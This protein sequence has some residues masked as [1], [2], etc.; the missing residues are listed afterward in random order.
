ME[1]CT[2]LTPPNGVNGLIDYSWSQHTNSQ[3][4]IIPWC[5]IVFF[6]G[7][8]PPRRI[9]SFCKVLKVLFLGGLLVTFEIFSKDLNNS[10]PTSFETYLSCPSFW[11][12]LTLLFDYIGPQCIHLVVAVG[13]PK[14]F[15]IVKL[16]LYCTGMMSS[17]AQLAS[18]FAIL[19][20]G[21]MTPMRQ[22]SLTYGLH[23]YEPAPSPCPHADKPMA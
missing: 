16:S 14:W 4:V 3:V 6:F 22:L 12:I 8:Q 5:G 13:I 20:Q 9:F 17:P 18:H 1:K 19:K 7:V 21:F 11:A 23:I 15:S 2:T 10:Q